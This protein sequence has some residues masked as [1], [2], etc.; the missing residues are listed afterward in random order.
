MFLCVGSRSNVFFLSFRFP[1][2]SVFDF[3]PSSPASMCGFLGAAHTPYHPL[4]LQFQLWF[5]YRP[6]H[7][8]SM[9]LLPFLWVYPRFL[10][11]TFLIQLL[12]LFTCILGCCPRAGPYAAAAFEDASGFALLPLPGWAS[13]LAILCAFHA[14]FASPS[15]DIL[16]GI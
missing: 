5:Y 1:T 13:L 10:P 8:R 6:T 11:Y 3:Y 14:I 7:Y 12:R 4:S 2:L 9:L 16:S 15:Q